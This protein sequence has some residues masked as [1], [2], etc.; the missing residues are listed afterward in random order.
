MILANGIGQ[1]WREIV[2][3]LL[4]ASP[5]AELRGGIPLGISAFNLNPLTVWALAVVGNLLPVV[6]L[7]LW[8]DPVS[9]FIAKRSTH[10]EAA[11][12]WLF[13]RT[14]KKHSDK[15]DRY[16]A[17]GLFVFVAIPAPGTGA[18]TG[19]LLAFLFGLPFRYA[20]LAV[21]AG[22]LGAS[23]V[24]MGAVQGVSL[25]SRLMDPRLMITLIALVIAAWLINRLVRSKAE[26][27]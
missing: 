16:G 9:R 17:F 2:V 3:L 4:S 24:V 26:G 12:S 13:E 11:L 1:I 5:V 15:I 7:L 18:W 20:V 6:P 10:L 25:A 23:L 27:R 22:V 19:C 14:R 8:L 21:S